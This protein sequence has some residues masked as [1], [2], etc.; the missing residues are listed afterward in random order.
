MEN[1]DR[2]QNDPWYILAD[3]LNAL[4]SDEREQSLQVLRTFVHD[5]RQTLG[6]IHSAVNLMQPTEGVDDTLEEMRELL[7]VIHVASKEAERLLAEF[8]GR[9]VEQIDPDRSE[10]TL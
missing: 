3:R 8:T 9:F 5:L 4:P 2:D 7:D 6:Q 10:K 1:N